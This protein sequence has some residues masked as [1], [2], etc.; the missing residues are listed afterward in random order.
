VTLDPSAAP[1]VGLAGDPAALVAF[2]RD[3]ASAEDGRVTV[4]GDR[5]RLARVLG[6]VDVADLQ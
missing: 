3:P 5:A 4:T 2:L 1:D 6:S